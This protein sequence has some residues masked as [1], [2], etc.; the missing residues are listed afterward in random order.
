M[1][2]SKVAISPDQVSSNWNKG[3]KGAV[4]KMQAGVNAV[5]DSPMERAAANVD[6]YVQ[7][8]AASAD[9]YV[10]GLRKTTLADWKRNTS[11]KIGQRMSGGVDAAMPKRQDFD[12]YL[13]NTLNGVLPQV[14]TMPNRSIDEGLAK[15]RAVVEHMHNNPFKR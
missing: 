15:V 5:T 7:G 4:P 14:A 1:A 10:A 13:V 6:A 9:R 2:K 8:V 12:R 3:M 11:D